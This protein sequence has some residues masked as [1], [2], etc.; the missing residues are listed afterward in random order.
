MDDLPNITLQSGS[1]PTWGTFL[2]A[3]GVILRL[4]LQNRKLS[5]DSESGIRDHYA[6]E[7]AGLR[8]QVLAVQKAADAR[9]A[10]AEARYTEAIE[11]AD[12]RH[13][14]CEEECDRLRDRV[15]AMER[16]FRQLH[17]STMRLF[18]PR[19]GLDPATADKLRSLEQLG[20]E[21]ERPAYGGDD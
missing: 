20:L 14:T 16:K 6:K 15:V 8:A 10:N 3:F 11:A 19:A 17:E 13:A 5:L 1:L 7:L 21:G 9:V 18:E 4:W 12:R 2:L